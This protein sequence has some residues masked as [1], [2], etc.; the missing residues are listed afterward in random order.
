MSTRG[1]AA[2]DH[3]ARPQS[4]PRPRPRPTAVRTRPRRR[5][6]RVRL[7]LL[8]IPLVALLFAGVVYINSAELALVK[9]QG[10]VVRQ[11]A[12]VQEQLAR[13][14]ARQDKIDVTVR[15]RAEN[16]GM[17]SPSSDALRY[18]AAR[19]APAPTP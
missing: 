11:T 4:S 3:V 1:A 15:A 9:R 6:F 12:N 18:V 10:Q 5:R 7:G 8:S 16:M 17:I 19:P 14:N 2:R 13:L